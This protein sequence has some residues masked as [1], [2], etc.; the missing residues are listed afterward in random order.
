MVGYLNASRPGFI[1]EGWEVQGTLTYQLGRHHYEY[2]LLESRDG[3][4]KWIIYG[5][6]HN[7]HTYE[8][9]HGKLFHEKV[10]PWVN[11]RYIPEVDSSNG[12][13]MKSLTY[14]DLTRGKLWHWFRSLTRRGVDWRIVFTGPIS[15]WPEDMAVAY[16]HL[17]ESNTGKR[18]YAVTSRYLIHLDPIDMPRGL[19]QSKIRPWLQG[20]NFDGIPAYSDMEKIEL[21]EKLSI[22]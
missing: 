14:F 20:K 13:A 12:K 16:Y 17:F 15:I 4:R 2:Y 21:M 22:D 1:H 5:D 9:L 8:A 19:F 18:R 11:G 6:H 10:F 3:A 7:S